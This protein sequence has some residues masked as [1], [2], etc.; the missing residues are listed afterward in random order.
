MADQSDTARKLETDL[1]VPVFRPVLDLP[2]S[3]ARQSAK[4]WGLTS[5]SQGSTISRATILNPLP[6]GQSGLSPYFRPMETIRLR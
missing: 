1:S 2:I 6:R 5:L 3:M 4:M